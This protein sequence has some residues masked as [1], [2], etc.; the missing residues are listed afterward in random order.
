MKKVK[1]LLLIIKYLHPL[2]NKIK[3]LFLNKIQIELVFHKMVKIYYQMI[4]LFL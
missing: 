2:K 1:Y 3:K 4:Y